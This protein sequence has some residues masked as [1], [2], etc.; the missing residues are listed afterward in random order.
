[1][2]AEQ[3]EQISKLIDTSQF[4]SMSHLDSFKSLIQK[5]VRKLSDEIDGK[6]VTIL[7]QTPFKAMT[8]SKMEE[9]IKKLKKMTTDAEKKDVEL[10]TKLATKATSE[11]LQNLEK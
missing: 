4:I 9:I 3:I 7:E 6:Y 2:N 8:A 11:Q 10:E 1:M 5:Q